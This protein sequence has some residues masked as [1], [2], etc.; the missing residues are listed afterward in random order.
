MLLNDVEI[1]RRALEDEMI[2][3]FLPELISKVEGR[4][5]LSFGQSSYGYDIR[6]AAKFEIMHNFDHRPMDPK[7]F[8]LDRDFNTVEVPMFGGEPVAIPAHGFALAK[9][10]EYMRIPR[11][12]VGWLTT[13][14]SYARCGLTVGGSLILEPEWE[15]FITLELSVI[16]PKPV[17][18][19]P[20]EGIAQVVFLKAD[21][22]CRTS[23]A[24][25]KGK[26]QAQVDIT[27][28]RM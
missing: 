24:D 19:W 21:E 4:K 23:Y 10:I 18:V 15:G 8:Q 6:P 26:Y 3:P 7:D 12:C 11:D 13:K 1:T 9:S 22:V 25:R 17:Y 2:D 5:V 14:S 20:N 28:A 16:A 27:P